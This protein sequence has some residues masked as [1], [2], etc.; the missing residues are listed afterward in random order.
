MSLAPPGGERGSGRRFSGIGP[1]SA[2]ERVGGRIGPGPRE[3]QRRRGS[4]GEEELEGADRI[5]DVRAPV[6]VRVVPP[7]APPAG[8][9]AGWE[10]IGSRSHQHQLQE[11]Q[12]ASPHTSVG[13]RTALKPQNRQLRVRGGRC[14]LLFPTRSAA[15]PGAPSPSVSVA[16]C[17]REASLDRGRG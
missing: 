3:R 7:N 4:S 8:S 16:P 10:G 13:A 2:A 14:A 9:G 15:H 5:R 1:S 6:V 11:S 12:R 17:P